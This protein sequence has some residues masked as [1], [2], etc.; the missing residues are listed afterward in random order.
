MLILSYSIGL[1]AI[2]GTYLNKI[3]PE[4]AMMILLVL[5]LS[6]VAYRTIYHGCM[7]FKAETDI[8]NEKIEDDRSES[9]REIELF[10]N[11]FVDIEQKENMDNCNDMMTHKG[12]QSSCMANSIQEKALHLPILSE[13]SG[14]FAEKS[15]SEKM[16]SDYRSIGN[17]SS[18]WNSSVHTDA[19]TEADDIKT[20]VSNG[21]NRI[22]PRSSIIINKVDSVSE[23]GLRSSICCST[24]NSNKGSRESSFDDFATAAFLV[25]E[26][27][28]PEILREIDR[29]S[30]PYR[31]NP[32]IDH[33]KKGK[34]DASLLSEISDEPFEYD[35]RHLKY[36]PNKKLSRSSTANLFE[37]KVDNA[38]I[39][40]FICNY[41]FCVPADGHELLPVSD[42]DKFLP[43]ENSESPSRV[44]YLLSSTDTDDDIGLFMTPSTSMR[45]IASSNALSPMYRSTNNGELLAILDIEASIPIARV[46]LLMLLITIVT[47]LTL[48]KSPQLAGVQCG[49]GQYWLITFSVFLII[50]VFSVIFGRDVVSRWRRKVA[51]NYSFIEGDV[52]WTQRNAL[53]YPF[54]CMW[55]GV[56]AGT[57]GV[58]GGVVKGPLMLEMSMHPL[59]VSATSAVMIFF[60]SLSASSR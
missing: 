16:E 11:E 30:P 45:S 5:L 53:L 12:V 52:Q 56:F 51:L 17:D 3:L 47:I 4:L 41:Y 38:D 54:L 13:E 40:E 23:E 24:S 59:V 31:K 37:A 60:T 43:E 32:E 35:R 34:R 46:G 14:L 2:L 15:V 20:A 49:S 19:D 33:G 22:S 57:F 44:G 8:L 25:D 27:L 21:Q 55:A 6:F 18:M 58:G 36:A 7:L 39:D 26:R 1:G 42:Q 29:Q 28:L 10:S 48:F 9:D 50:I